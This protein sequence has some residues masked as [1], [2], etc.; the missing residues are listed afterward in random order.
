MLRSRHTRL[1]GAFNHL[2]IFV[3]P[4]PDPERSWAERKRLFEL[5]RS[6]WTDYDATLIS[7]GGGVFGRTS[8]SLPVSP[9]MKRLFGIEAEHTP[10]S[11][12]IAAILRAEHDLIWFDGTVT[13]FQ[14]SAENHSAVVDR[15]HAA[16]SSDGPTTH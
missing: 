12:L 5:P 15:A 14:S 11:G 1:V 16:T 7:T 3:D 13:L 4:D 8:K 6:N 10:P 9:E 2:P